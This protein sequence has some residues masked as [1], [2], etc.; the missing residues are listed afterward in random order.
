MWKRRRHWNYEDR[1]T[2]APDLSLLVLALYG[3]GGLLSAG[4]PLPPAGAPLLRQYRRYG[5]PHN[6]SH[7]RGL[8]NR[9]H[10][11][12][13]LRP[14]ADAPPSSLTADPTSVFPNRASLCLHASILQRSRVLA[15]EQAISSAF[16]SNR[17]NS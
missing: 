12:L 15:H 7:L 16:S 4:R 17:E 9:A 6:R 13:R 11:K 8:R 2:T 1:P 5:D 14:P 10:G 3:I